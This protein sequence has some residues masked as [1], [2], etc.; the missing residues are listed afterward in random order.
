MSIKLNSEQ[1][2]RQ[3]PVIRIVRLQQS[4]IPT[5]LSRLEISR[6]REHESQSMPTEWILRDR[7]Y[8]NGKTSGE[9]ENRAVWGVLELNRRGVKGM[10]H[11]PSG[12]LAG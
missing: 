9:R 12:V 8:Y 10:T 3:I 2:V 4:E 6:W 7:D 1:M 11:E 5:G